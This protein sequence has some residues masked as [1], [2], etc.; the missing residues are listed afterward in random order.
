MSNQS[1]PGQ[2]TASS[3]P[4]PRALANEVWGGQG[5]SLQINDKGAEIEYDCAHGT[6][7]EKIVPDGGA[8]FAVKGRHVRERGGPIR[9]DQD[10]SG[11]PAIYRGSIDGDTMT[12]TVTLSE[13]DEKVGTYTLTR[14]KVGRIRKCL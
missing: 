1:A 12:L 3:S 2:S 8:K 11:Q 7:T 4:H 9:A 10:D 6:I 14:G 5:I 13:S